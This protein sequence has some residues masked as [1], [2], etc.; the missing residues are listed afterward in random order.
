MAASTNIRFLY[1]L[2][3]PDTYSYLLT[4]SLFGSHHAEYYAQLGRASKG[5]NR[6]NLKIIEA[7]PRGCHLATGCGLG[8][9]TSIVLGTKDSY[10]TWWA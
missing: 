3:W 2:S 1:S 9:A 5:R 4:S 6:T 10:L 8:R 7:Y